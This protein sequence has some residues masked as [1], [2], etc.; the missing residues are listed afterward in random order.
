MQIKKTVLIALI[1]RICLKLNKEKKLEK[2]CLNYHE[3][4]IGR[5]EY[6]KKRR[7]FA[8]ALLGNGFINVS[9][10]V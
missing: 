4:N 1:A 5:V 2:N 3:I 6:K 7:H 9:T 10:F 8:M